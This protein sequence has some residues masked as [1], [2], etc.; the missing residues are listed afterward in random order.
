MADVPSP[1][2]PALDADTDQGLAY[3]RDC[4]EALARG[5]PEARLCLLLADGMAAPLR[6]QFPGIPAG[7]VLMSAARSMEALKREFAGKGFGDADA[8][9]TVAMLAAEALERE[10]IDHA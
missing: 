5:G 9:L 3:A 7:R 10:E 6:E 4:R 8:L 2:K 1:P